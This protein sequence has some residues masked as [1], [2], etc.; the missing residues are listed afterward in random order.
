MQFDGTSAVLRT[1]L[2]SHDHTYLHTSM[3]PTS[4][5]SIN[6]EKRKKSAQFGV[7]Q[8]ALKHISASVLLSIWLA[9]L[10]LSA[11]CIF[12]EQSTAEGS[13]ELPCIPTSYDKYIKRSVYS[14]KTSEFLPLYACTHRSLL[15]LTSGY[16]RRFLTDI[17]VVAEGR[18]GQ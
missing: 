6:R 16:Y 3:M 18:S 9:T 1:M 11:N 17:P 2:E 12:L 7:F 15:Q 8:D 5:D 14:A 10:Q 13:N 4:V